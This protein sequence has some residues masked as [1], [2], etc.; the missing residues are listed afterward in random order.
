[1]VVPKKGTAGRGRQVV[2]HPW[3]VQNALLSF[4]G[5]LENWTPEEQD[6][7]L[8]VLEDRYSIFLPHCP[9]EMQLHARTLLDFA[10]RARKSTPGK[11][12]S[13]Q[14]ATNATDIL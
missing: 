14:F 2:T 6:M 8:D 4:W 7:A 13:R 9:C 10:K 3:Q 5:M 1:M 11:K 12:K